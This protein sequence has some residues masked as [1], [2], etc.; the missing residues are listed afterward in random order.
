AAATIS[1]MKGGMMIDNDCMG[2]FSLRCAAIRCVLARTGSRAFD[3][4]EH[5][6]RRSRAR[7]LGDAA[8][9][10]RTGCRTQRFTHADREHER[11]LSDSLA[12]VHDARLG[13]ALQEV[14]LEHR[15][16]LTQARQ[17]VG[18]GAA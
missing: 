11:W 10:E 7:E 2:F 13:G 12:S 18:R 1:S 9:T 3:R 4:P 15:R 14:D 16:T 17:L 6:F 8:T 5:G